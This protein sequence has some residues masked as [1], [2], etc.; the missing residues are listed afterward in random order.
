MSPGSDRAD[1]HRRRER[2]VPPAARG[3][4]P[5]SPFEEQFDDPELEGGGFDGLDGLGDRDVLRVDTTQTVEMPMPLGARSPGLTPFAS[6]EA[7][8]WNEG[9]DQNDADAS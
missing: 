7:T 6:V 3:N 2:R 4:R 8:A 5:H 1:P 9:V